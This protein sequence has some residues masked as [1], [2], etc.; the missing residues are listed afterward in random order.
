MYVAYVS[1]SRCRLCAVAGYVPTRCYCL[2]TFL[3]GLAQLKESPM[4][5]AK[6]EF[7]FQLPAETV[8]CRCTTAPGAPLGL[9]G[10]F[11]FQPFKFSVSR[12]L[13]HIQF[14]TFLDS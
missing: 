13:G 11:E 9:G 1:G 8:S 3:V 2:F 10:K 14:N 6:I 4:T 7:L 12:F 5:C